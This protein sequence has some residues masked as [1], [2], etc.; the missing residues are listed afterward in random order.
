MEY[1]VPQLLIEEL[2]KRNLV[3]EKDI[4]VAK[5]EAIK[6]NVD[7]GQIIVKNGLVDDSELLKIKSEIYNI[8]AFDLADFKIE[9]SVLEGISNHVIN[10]YYVLPLAKKDGYLEV[11]IL[12]PENIGAL[13]AVK[14]L[15]AEQNL[16]LKQYVISYSDFSN[17]TK[18]FSVLTSEIDKALESIT[19]AK[20]AEGE[21][22]AKIAGEDSDLSRITAD[23]PITKA[24]ASIVKHA[25]DMKASD[26]HIE[27]F[28]N[29]IRLRL[30]IDGV[31][32]TVLK[33]PIKLLSSLVTRIKIL[34]DLKIDETRLA[35][36]GRFSTNFNQRVIDFRVSTFPTRNGEKVVMRILDP[37]SGVVE[38]T[39]LGVRGRSHK[40]LLENMEKPFGAILITGPTGSG[41]STTLAAILRKMNVEGVNI[42]TLED[43]IEYF[44][45][46]VN[47]SQVHEEIGYTFAS[48]LRHIL[49][50]DPDIIM[51]G[52]IRDGETAQ[53]ATQAALT[54][55][56]VLSTVH[57][58]DTIGVIPRLMDMGVERYL[59]APTLNLAL[60]Q[61]LMRKLCPDC[62]KE[63]D[64]SPSEKKMIEKTL[65][66]MPE[67]AKK[68]VKSDYKLFKSAG[69][70]TCNKNGY[71]G[72]MG[73]FETLEMTDNL[74]RIVLSDLSEEK[75]REEAKRQG[76]ITMF[77]DGLLK[78][79]D[80]ITSMEQLLQVASDSENPDVILEEEQKPKE[81]DII[82]PKI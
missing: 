69:C 11:G 1:A 45:E 16:K 67:S 28:R 25:V 59:L 39:D 29:D 72:R 24:V 17:F 7:L 60:A 26:I 36:D 27:P 81:K 77:Q 82:K 23:A 54:G 42:V 13:E 64:A 5:E 34:S 57:T 56:V 70:K 71:K 33:L 78:V 73:I 37:L 44:V 79:L 31:M 49:R 12:N 32:R 48:G 6:E 8:P 46:G 30:R 58:N 15:A 19:P 52:E 76:M 2:L 40:L 10:M 75:L 43:P 61:R 62:K 68:D 80:G 63:Y 65:S 22:M 51:V 18:S 74:E 53:L 41:K 9:K 3:K 55:H 4:E 47:Q 14:F 66:E 38:L 50:Q 35:Q 21:D 20:K